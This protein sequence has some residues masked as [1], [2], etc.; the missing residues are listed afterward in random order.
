MCGIAGFTAW[1]GPLASLLLDEMTEA[2]RHRGP[3][4]EGKWGLRPTGEAVAWR[5]R[6]AHHLLQVGLGHRRL[7]ILD[8]TEAGAQPMTSRDGRYHVT[9]NGEIYNFV[10]LREGLRDGAWRGRSD[11][12]V[13]LELFARRRERALEALNGIFAFAIYDSAERELW[14]VRDPLGV[15][16]LYYFQDHRGLFF[17]SE[18]RALRLA[19]FESPRL[20]LPL[21]GRYLSAGWVPDPDTLLEGVRKLEPGHYLVARG[22]GEVAIK[23]YWQYRYEPET[24]VSRSA[25]RERVDEALDRSLERQ[26]RS[27]VPVAFFLSGGID[28]SLLV[29][30]A[31]RLKPRERVPTY[32]IGFRWGGKG[33]EQLDLASARLL[34]RKLSLDSREILLEPK[35]VELLPKVVEAL[36]EPV[37]DPAALCSF[38]LCEAASREFKV[39]VSGQGGDELFGGYPV[40]LGGRWARGL[41]RLPGPMLQGLSLVADSL[42]YRVGGTRV[43]PVHRARRLFSTSLS[44]WPMPFFSLRSALPPEALHS[45]LTPEALDAQEPA[46][47]KHLLHFEAARAW[48]A[49]QQMMYLDLK[50][51]L[52]STNL[53]YTD[54]TSMAHGVEVRVPLLDLELVDIARRIPSR[55]KLGL[56]RSK[57]LLKAISRSAL[58]AELLRRKKAGFG[59]PLRDW[60][61]EDLQPMARE[62]LSP[63][64]LA[65]Q[66]LFQPEQVG[67]WLDEHRDGR[68]DHGPRLYSLMSFQLWLDSHGI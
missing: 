8:L 41:G 29:A 5:G 15:K 21:L 65:R 57:I 64:R 31:A 39:L 20:R 27:D 63:E 25:W 32:T 24:A 58:P 66:R 11:T 38:L 10:E 47:A 68:A 42:P 43:Q 6:E 48:D 4:G 7:S 55:H 61:R 59:I 22:D 52:P 19:S 35:I 17:A 45:L 54:K 18:L 16:P 12:E 51:Y 60:M 23:P 26:L 37:A 44:P 40:Y 33:A 46:F 49:R 53:T 2:V 13:L 36:E 67:R 14:L 3:D 1:R 28:S 9:Y 50:T 30:K 62:L 34:A 56:A